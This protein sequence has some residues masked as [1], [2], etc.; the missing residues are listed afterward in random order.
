MVL[1]SIDRVAPY[2]CL[3][4]EWLAPVRAEVPASEG[5]LD[6]NESLTLIASPGAVVP[7]HVDN[8]H[9]VLFQL[10]GTKQLFVGEFS[11]AAAGAGPGG[12]ALRRDRVST[13]TDSPTSPRATP[14]PRATRFYLP[15]YTSHWVV[16][17]SEHSVAVSCSFRTEGVAPRPAGIRMQRP[18]AEVGSRPRPPGQVMLRD[19][20]KV[21]ALQNV[22]RHPTIRLRVHSRPS[23]CERPS[24]R[25]SRANRAVNSIGISHAC[26]RPN[27]SWR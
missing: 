5:R 19:R 24:W 13:S 17:G 11:D 2:R 27:W 23:R 18:A 4:D 21:S 6:R 9:N 3:V 20:A 7:A 10:E 25:T 12:A 1:W 14:W 16:G 8:N 15:P 22:D 26:A